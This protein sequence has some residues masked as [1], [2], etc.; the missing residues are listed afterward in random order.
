MRYVFAYNDRFQIKNLK[1]GYPRDQINVLN[2]YFYW[3]KCK[4]NRQWNKEEL[5]YFYLDSGA[6]TAWTRKVEIDIDKY[7]ECINYHYKLFEEKLIAINLDIIPGEFGRTPTKKEVEDA[8]KKGLD[9]YYY[10]KE[11]TDA[12]IMP[13]FH[14]HDDW[15]YLKTYIEDDC[16]VLGISPAN[17]LSTKKRKP[18]LDKVFSMVKLQKRCHGLAA[19]SP[20]LMQRYP[21]FSCDSATWV[22]SAGMGSCYIFKNG[23]IKHINYK[24]K[25]LVEKY[26]LLHLGDHNG[27]NYEERRRHNLKQIEK[28]ETYTTKLWEKKGIKWDS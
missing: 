20:E 9:N 23:V 24:N 2:S 25:K 4:D 8:C 7:I 6:F 19:T 1:E 16:F 18:W 17:D 14:Q 21:F 15:K 22:M 26:N 10:I 27:K 12:K 28:L 3:L 5:G 11:R 13:V